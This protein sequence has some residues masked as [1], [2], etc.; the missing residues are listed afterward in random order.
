MATRKSD[1]A[2]LSQE[3]QSSAYAK[4]YR[5]PVRHLKGRRGS[6]VRFTSHV[7]P[8]DEGDPG[9]DREAPASPGR[10]W[11]RVVEIG[12]GPEQNIDGA[13]DRFNKAS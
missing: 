11:Q 2:P 5:D 4:Y 10:I 6:D 8:R 1:L 3:E 9:S 12:V 7:R 13:A